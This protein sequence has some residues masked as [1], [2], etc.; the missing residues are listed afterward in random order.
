MEVDD[1]EVLDELEK[2]TVV[3]GKTTDEVSILTVSLAV[4]DVEEL[5]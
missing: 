5:E 4:S 3:D 2:D 1:A